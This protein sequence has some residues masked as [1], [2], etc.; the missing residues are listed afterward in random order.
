MI[1]ELAPVEISGH[2]ASVVGGADHPMRVV[3]RRAAGLEDEG[4]TPGT[5]AE[6]ARLFDHLAD[7]WHTRCSPQRTAVVTDA[8]E[9]GGIGGAVCIEVGSGIGSYSGLL[10][11]R[12]D[13]VVAVD[14]AEEMLRRAPREP[15]ARVLADASQLPVPAGIADAVVLIN[16]FLF[17]AEVD[18]V[19]APEGAVLWVN[20]SG[21]QTPIHLSA[22]EV[23]EALPG[24]WS[25]AA[26]RAGAGT[27][28]ALR[29]THT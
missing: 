15:A 8:L 3:T 28:C 7:E 25:G 17:P 21:E 13:T 16:A 22:A 18:R 19:L 6:V 4:W 11:E 14:L 12:F 1:E 20:S 9:R 10:A 5:R 24:A 29:R 27:W 26:S 23:D 2:E